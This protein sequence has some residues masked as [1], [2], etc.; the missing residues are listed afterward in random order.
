MEMRVRVTNTA[1]C[2]HDV[3]HLCHLVTASFRAAGW[4]SVLKTN[5][6]QRQRLLQNKREMLVMQSSTGVCL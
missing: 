1:V 2:M 3:S 4:G 5:V 6:R